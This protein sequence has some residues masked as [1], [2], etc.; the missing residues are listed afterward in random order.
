M[1]EHLADAVK[2]AIVGAADRDVA[3]RASERLIRGAHAVRGAEPLRDP[4][5]REVL[6]RFPHREPD[7]CIEERGVDLLAL[8]CLVAMLERREDADRREHPGAE[9]RER[10]A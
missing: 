5:A 6:R 10:D 2:A 1:P 4:A 3:V 8:S 9:I 7:A